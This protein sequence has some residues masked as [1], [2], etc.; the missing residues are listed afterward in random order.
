MVDCR[1]VCSSG[2]GIVLMMTNKR[3]KIWKRSKEDPRSKKTAV[4]YCCVRC[5][6]C[7]RCFHQCFHSWKHWEETLGNI[8]KHW[9]TLIGDRKHLLATGNIFWRQETFCGYRKHFVVTGNKA[10]KSGKSKKNQ[11]K[12]QKETFRDLLNLN[13]ES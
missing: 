8:R 9:E 5:F 3:S 1:I 4:F 10:V 2:C 11:T 13:F 12:R 7:F 6:Q